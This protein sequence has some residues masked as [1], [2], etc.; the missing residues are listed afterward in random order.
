MPKLT[1]IQI[2]HYGDGKLDRVTLPKKTAAENIEIGDF[3]KFTTDGVELMTAAADAAT[4]VGISG[5]LSKNAEGPRQ[6]LVYQKCMVVLPS[7]SGTY[8]PGDGLKYKPANG[9]VEDDQDTTPGNTIAW[10]RDLTPAASTTV[11]AWVD[12]VGLQK[13][14]GVE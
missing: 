4:F 12:V 1:A 11:K 8:K 5:T 13:L 6:I 2:R 14:Y 10:S 7:E 9:T 3:L